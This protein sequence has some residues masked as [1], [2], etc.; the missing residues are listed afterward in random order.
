MKNHEEGQKL[1]E[2]GMI[3]ASQY[4]CSDAI[5]YYTLSIQ[6][7]DNPAP[8]INR[9]NI[10]GKRIRHFEALQD[11]LRARRLDKEQNDEFSHEI[12]RDLALAVALTNNYSSGQRDKLIDDLKKNGA[13][14]VAN[15]VLCASFGISQSKWEYDALSGT[16]LEYHYFNELDNIGKFDDLNNYPEAARPLELYAPEF[17]KNKVDS[18]SASDL[19]A[20]QLMERQLHAFLCSYD[21][22]D[23]QHVR[24]HI[25]YEIEQKLMARDF[26]EFWDSLDSECNGITLEAE[27]FISSRNQ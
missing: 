4:K 17:I 26:G 9:A 27:E 3:Y 12:N 24:R 5:K 14:Y 16:F 13:A 25:L 2:L 1:F 20:Y 18:I 11:L 15:R 6:A 23:M 7:H 10:L 22:N 19:D 21:E 8:Y